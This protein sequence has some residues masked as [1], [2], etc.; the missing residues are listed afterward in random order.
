MKKN[1]NYLNFIIHIHVTP[2]LRPL[3][4]ATGFMDP[5]KI[6]A[7]GLSSRTSAATIECIC[8]DRLSFQVC[9]D[10]KDTQRCQE[11][12]EQYHQ[13]QYV[14]RE[15]FWITKEQYKEFKR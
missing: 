7:H 13:G 2:P 4:N 5:K 15:T 1:L 12:E 6:Q 8:Y 11:V 9:P 3:M 10:P 14:A